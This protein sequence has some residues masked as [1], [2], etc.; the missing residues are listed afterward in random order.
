M[1]RVV[2]PYKMFNLNRNKSIEEKKS[3]NHFLSTFLFSIHQCAVWSVRFA[4][5]VWDVSNKRALLTRTPATLW[6]TAAL[7]CLDVTDHK[8]VMLSGRHT[9]AI[10][11]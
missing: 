1:I 7:K 6:N 10:L 3:E 4:I 8:I 5:Q 9:K 11:T 2:V